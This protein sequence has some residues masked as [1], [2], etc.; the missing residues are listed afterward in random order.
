MAKWQRVSRG[1]GDCGKVHEIDTRV[2]DTPI[3]ASRKYTDDQLREAV[4][5]CAST[6]EVL[7]RLGL[8][9]CG[10]NYESVLHRAERLGLDTTHLTAGSRHASRRENVSDDEF[11][12]AVRESRSIAEALRRLGLDPRSDYDFF[13]RKRRALALGIDHFSGQAWRGKTRGVSRRRLMDL[14]RK[15]GLINTSRLK[16]RLFEAGLKDRRCEW[17][18][19]TRW[20][21]GEA[22]LELDHVNGDRR[23][24]RLENLRILCPNCHALT[25]TYRGRRIGYT[26]PQRRSEGA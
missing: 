16:Q 21:G 24:N 11:A 15:G 7:R 25:A 10:G 8:V 26:H 6:A 2:C 23:D 19:I 12:A 4:T 14:L 9:A 22:P 18:G 20:R 13:H 5:G 3:M 17:C 1:R